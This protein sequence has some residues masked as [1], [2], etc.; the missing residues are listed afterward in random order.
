MGSPS[1]V[2]LQRLSQTV[3]LT[4]FNAFMATTVACACALVQTPFAIGLHWSLLWLWPLAVL[5]PLIAY[6]LFKDSLPKDLPADNNV[7]AKQGEAPNA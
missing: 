4:D 6:L 2:V 5:L 1:E 3:G 7:E